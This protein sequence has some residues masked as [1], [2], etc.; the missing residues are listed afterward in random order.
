[1]STGYVCG[2]YL[3]RVAANTACLQMAGDAPRLCDRFFLLKTIHHFY[4]C[5][6]DT[7][8]YAT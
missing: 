3:C 4:L 1:L 8:V 6:Y 2:V 7:A 5:L